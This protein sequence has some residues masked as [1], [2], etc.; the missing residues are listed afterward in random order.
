MGGES[1]AAHADNTGIAHLGKQLLIGQGL[2]IRQLLS[3]A[4]RQGVGSV[5]FHHNGHRAAAG[6]VLSG[7]HRLDRAGHG[8]MNVGGHEP[9]GLSDHLTGQNLVTLLNHRRGRLANVLIGHI[10]QFALREQGLQSAFLGKLLV[11]RGMN[12]AMECLNFHV[13][14]S[15][16]TQNFHGIAQR[17]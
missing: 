10:D 14:L 12:T 1:G 9:S 7:L 4:L 17:A 13:H 5:V 3:H 11:A 8:A 2:H 15:L 6:G 16:F